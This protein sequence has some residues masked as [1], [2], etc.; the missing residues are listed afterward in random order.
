M[1]VSLSL[2]VGDYDRTRAIFDGRAPIEGCDVTAVMLEPE[3]AFD[4]IMAD[5][6]M[7]KM[8]GVELLREA[9]TLQP[10]AGRIMIT[11]HAELAEV[12]AAK[13]AGLAAVVIMK[14]WQREELLR[15]VTHIHGVAQMRR[16]VDQMSAKLGKKA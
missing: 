10:D 15:W 6:A 1:A 4:V 5:Y 13:A 11:A 12:K 9:Q 3:E 2:A 14:P 8:N 16:S 7:P